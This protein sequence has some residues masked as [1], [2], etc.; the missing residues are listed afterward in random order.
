MIG[1]LSRSSYAPLMGR[2]YFGDFLYALL[3]FFIVGFVFPRQ[4]TFK[5]AVISIF[6][7][8][9]IEVGQLC[10]ADWLNTIRSYRLGG[11]IL[12]HGFLWS[13]LVSYTFGGLTGAVMDFFINKK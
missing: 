10:Q 5:V 3:F 13:D 1:L 4:P 8:F 12:G 6:A 2:A 9:L 7:C 11:L